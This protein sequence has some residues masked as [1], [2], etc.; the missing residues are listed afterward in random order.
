MASESDP[1]AAAP[2]DDASVATL[3]QLKQAET[4]W[5]ERL[6]KAKADNGA[7]LARLK[8]EADHAVERARARAE[9][10]RDAKLRDARTKAESEAAEI[11]RIGE[12]E[13]LTVA[14]AD[15]GD[16]EGSRRRI[17]DAVLGPFRPTPKKGA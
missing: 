12:L 11:V 8:A 6:A 13:A 9:Q 17:L 15:P 7:E 16:D 4:E 1:H 14:G 3:R 2:V 5:S 10:D